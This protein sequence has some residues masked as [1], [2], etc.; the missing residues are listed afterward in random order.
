[1]TGAGGAAVRA[2]IPIL[3]CLAV[4][5]GSTGAARAAALLPGGNAKQPINIE[6]L[7]LDYFDKEQKLIY[8]GNVV[9]TQGD[10]KLKAS[11]L[12]IFLA[13]KSGDASAPSNNSVQRMLAAGPVVLLQRDQVGTG[14]SGVYDKA[15]NTVVLTGNVTL[16]QGPNV[17]KGEKLIYDLHSGQAV[18]RG[19]ASGGVKSMFLPNS[20]SGGT[21]N[22]EEPAKKTKVRTRSGG[23]GRAAAEGNGG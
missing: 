18:V 22:A 14:D 23:Q 9:A 11:V 2:S 21:A 17:T 15:S 12:T 7:K 19:G 1:M 6:A 20:G 8:T 10:S 3:T 13:P 16:S 4:L 5:F